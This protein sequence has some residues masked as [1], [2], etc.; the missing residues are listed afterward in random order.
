ML[1]TFVGESLPAVREQVRAPF[2]RYLRS[3]V[4]L[5][6][7]DFSHLAD[8]PGP[9]H[10]SA[11]DAAFERCGAAPGGPVRVR[12]DGAGSG[13]EGAAE[14]A[15]DA[16][17]AAPGR[18][19]GLGRAGEG[20]VTDLRPERLY[21]QQRTGPPVPADTP[22]GAQPRKETSCPG[23]IPVPEPVRCSFAS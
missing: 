6:R 14:P 10:D 4:G 11:V 5:W 20:A 22:R 17:V 9:V 19:A 18:L 21:Q 16:A 12:P 15:A 1:H 7:N 2:T 13:V 23:E 3:S 8:L